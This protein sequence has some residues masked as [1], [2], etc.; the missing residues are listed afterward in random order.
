VSHGKHKPPVILI[1]THH[2]PVCPIHVIDLLSCRP[3]PDFPDLGPAIAMPI[4]GIVRPACQLLFADGDRQPALCHCH[5][6]KQL[7]QLINAHA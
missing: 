1:Q 6:E 7:V 5:A 2:K 4:A 3:Q